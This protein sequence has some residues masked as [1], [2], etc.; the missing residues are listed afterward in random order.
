MDTSDKYIKM[1]KP[2]IP[3]LETFMSAFL[4][5]QLQIVQKFLSS[6]KATHIQAAMGEYI[7]FGINH[8]KEY[9]MVLQPNWTVMS[10]FP[11]LIQ[12]RLPKDKPES[13]TLKF[14]PRGDTRNIVYGTFQ[15]S[16]QIQVSLFTVNVAI[17]LE[18]EEETCKFY[19]TTEFERK[20]NANNEWNSQQ[21]AVTKSVPCNLR[22]V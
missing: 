6:I 8:E 12:K 16:M 4:S 22:I 14:C 9:E 5:T 17:V 10:A 21:K 13:V 18:I 7:W 11:E 15:W 3:N 1:E 20:E 19:L 2:S